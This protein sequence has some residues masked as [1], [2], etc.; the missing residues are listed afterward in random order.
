M[1]LEV[2]C[3]VLFLEFIYLFMVALSLHCFAQSFSTCNEDF[4]S[5]QQASFSWQFLL[6][7]SRI[8]RV[9]RLG[10]WSKQGYLLW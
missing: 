4:S 8:S 7:Q 6:L 9:P 10:S 5:L 1:Y 2:F 3:F